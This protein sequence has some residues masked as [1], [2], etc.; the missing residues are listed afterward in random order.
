MLIFGTD[1]TF[2][3]KKGTNRSVPIIAMNKEKIDSATPWVQYAY[4]LCHP[5]CFRNP[6]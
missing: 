1:E 4:K 6:V 2:E 5:V 3:E